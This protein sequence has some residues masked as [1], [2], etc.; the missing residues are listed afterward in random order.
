LLVVEPTHELRASDDDGGFAKGRA[1]SR[2]RQGS[3]A[4]Q[5][6]FVR[7]SNAFGASAAITISARHDGPFA[8][9]RG[10]GAGPFTSSS[11]GFARKEASI[12]NRLQGPADVIPG[13][14]APTRPWASQLLILSGLSRT[15][16]MA[17][18]G[19]NPAF[20]HQL[21]RGTCEGRFEG[22]I[23]AHTSGRGL[24]AVLHVLKGEKG[25]EGPRASWTAERQG[26]A[27]T[28]GEGCAGGNSADVQAPA[29]HSSSVDQGG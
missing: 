3:P 1:L 2:V 24:L 14:P 18:S 27:V 16:S 28:W 26:E 10:Q 12:S 6:A 5:T 17:G 9:V 21:E 22:K 13:P 15:S 11:R 19:R 25:V 29:C 7:G 8:F 20:G 23:E 4:Q